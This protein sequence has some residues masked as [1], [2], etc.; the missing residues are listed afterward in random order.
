MGSRLEPS[1]DTQIGTHFIG[2]DVPTEEDARS[3]RFRLRRI[4][5]EVLGEEHRTS[6]CGASPCASVVKVQK[7]GD[8]K[9]NF[10]GIYTCGS[11]WTCPVCASKIA[12]RRS[13]EVSDLVK[14]HAKAG[15]ASYMATLTVRHGLG[16]R[17]EG[18]RKTISKAWNDLMRSGSMRLLREKYNIV[19]YVR[20]LEVT[21]GQ[22]GWHPHLH[23]LFLARSM[24]C[25][26]Q[27]ACGDAIFT[28]W[29]HVLDKLKFEA[30]KVGFDFQRATNA[31]AAAQYVAK[32][33]AG[34]EIAKGSEKLGKAGR[35]P[36]QLLDDYKS[37]DEWAGR[38]YAE[39][40]D[41]FHGARHLTYAQK[42]REL[43]GLRQA[44]EDEQLAL[45]D[46]L[47]EYEDGQEI[48][49]IDL[50]M[51]GRLVKMCITAQVLSAADEGGANAIDELLIRHGLCPNS[52]RPPPHT[53]YRTPRAPRG[54]KVQNHGG[55]RNELRN[56][57]N[58]RRTGPKFS[59]HDSGA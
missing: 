55:V 51:W 26:E 36:W 32:W 40:A 6:R 27:T 33:G 39:Y 47:P 35:S 31:D 11:I 14:A 56:L 10:T 58:D 37:G 43:Y 28:R 53:K 21:H 41:G 50:G 54:L 15:Q 48:Y 17:C 49:Q 42:I 57:A 1:I 8:R 34:T 59:C 4:A 25:E 30:C 5:G 19:G 44:V 16:D 20:S 2:G 22:S 24:T 18:L 52:D 13:S 46:D 45:D 7:M 9:A 29:K 23:I 12:A 3:R 38:L